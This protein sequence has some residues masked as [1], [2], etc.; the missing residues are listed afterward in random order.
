MA[1]LLDDIRRTTQLS[2]T[3][4]LFLLTL[5]GFT[6]AGTGVAFPCQKTLA[7]GMSMSVATVQREVRLCL[8]LKL[9]EVR[10]RWRKSNV[11]RLLCLKERRLSTMTS[12]GDAREQPPYLEKN[13]PN[14]AAPP[15]VSPKEIHVLLGDI[16]EVLGPHLMNRNRGW[17]IK[18]IRACG[19]DMITDAVHR[20]RQIL[21][22]AEVTGG[23]IRNPSG[24]FTWFLRGAG[25]TI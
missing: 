2:P 6:D 22:E 15:G 13:V 7:T 21:M 9:L 12:P 23:E 3:T 25:M 11:Y 8:E 1:Y 20:V 24:L 10:R 19:W 14:D 16:E 17:F 18:Q 5:A 4:K